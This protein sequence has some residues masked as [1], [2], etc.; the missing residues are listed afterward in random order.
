[1]AHAHCSWKL[2]GPT[3]GINISATDTLSRL[4]RLYEVIDIRNPGR[5]SDRSINRALD[6][7]DAI[8]K[9]QLHDDQAVSHSAAPRSFF[10]AAAASEPD[11][12]DN[13]MVVR[14]LIYLLHTSWPMSQGW[15]RGSGEC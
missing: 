6:H 5:A 8:V 10:E 7:I 15:S 9:Q 3:A 14:N 13:Q 11:A 4:K 2:A 1:M 12:V